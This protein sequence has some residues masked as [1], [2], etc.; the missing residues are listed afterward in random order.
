MLSGSVIKEVIKP[1]G[2]LG[3]VPVWVNVDLLTPEGKSVLYAGKIE[4]NSYA[5]GLHQR[6]SKK[7]VEVSENDQEFIEALT[8]VKYSLEQTRDNSKL[9][10]IIVTRGISPH[11]AE[12]KLSNIRWILKEISQKKENLTMLCVLGVD[13]DK[14]VN[15]ASVF[16]PIRDRVTVASTVKE[17]QKGCLLK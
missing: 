11:I 15:T 10:A 5:L 2:A 1:K 17:E 8:R 12:K 6:I 16:E 4:G 7:L 3:E 9:R 13:I 14:R